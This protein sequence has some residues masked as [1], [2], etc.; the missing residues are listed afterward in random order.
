MPRGTFDSNGLVT[1]VYNPFESNKLYSPDGSKHLL[2]CETCGN[3]Q[4]VSIGTVSVICD[5]CA[6]NRDND[7]YEESFIERERRTR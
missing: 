1:I 2:P 5:S 3:V 4:W 6:N 7:G